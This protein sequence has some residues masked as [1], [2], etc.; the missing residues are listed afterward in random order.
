MENNACLKCGRELHYNDARVMANG[1][2]YC[3]G[4]SNNETSDKEQIEKLEK[5]IFLLEEFQ[6]MWSARVGTCEDKIGNMEQWKEKVEIIEK[7]IAELES[8]LHR[9]DLFFK[10]R[11]I[12]DGE[13]WLTV[14]HGESE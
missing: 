1:G 14:I 3:L 9:I 10:N 13:K 8:R 11:Y 7:R 5:R 12:Y 6:K 2:F 4:C